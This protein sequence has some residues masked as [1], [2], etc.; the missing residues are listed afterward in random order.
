M[1][2]P[3]A[4]NRADTTSW[5]PPLPEAPGFEHTRIETPG[6]RSHIA[7]IG[8]GAPVVMLHG[9]PE[10]WWQWHAIAPKLAERG[11]RAICPGLRGSAWTEAADPRFGPESHLDDLVA[12]LDALGIQ[13]AHFVC[14]DMG[15]IS[16]MQFAYRYPE[17]VRTMVQLSVPPG[18]MEFTPKLMPAFSHM[19]S[20]IMHR[21]GRS[22]RRLFTPRYVARPMSDAVID[23]YLRVHERA[24]VERAVSAVFR[25]MVVPVS[26]RLMLVY[27]RMHLRPPTLV[28]FG[29]QD[30]PFT[31]PTV[32]HVCRNHALHADRFELAFVDDAAHFI[33]DDAPDAVTALV[34]DWFERE[35]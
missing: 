6:L 15:A 8:E 26:F 24:E 3:Q 13:S 29:R 9:F 4:H 1:D 22:L 16:G 34:L 21:E 35:G 12:V 25:G 23:A 31:E 7:S 32:R 30:G 28:V 18:F 10:H 17:R 19:P 14:H 11:Y 5:T 2:A 27:K 33:T 20:L